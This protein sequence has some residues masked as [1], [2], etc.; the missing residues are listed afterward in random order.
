M[1]ALDSNDKGNKSFAL[2]PTTLAA[3]T[4]IMSYPKEERSFYDVCCYSTRFNVRN[5]PVKLFF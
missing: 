2:F 1:I 3:Q 5:Y 4:F